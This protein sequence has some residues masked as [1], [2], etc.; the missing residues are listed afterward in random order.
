MKKLVKLFA[1][2][3]VLVTAVTS[4]TDEAT[5]RKRAAANAPKPVIKIV[6][7][8][9]PANLGKI[10]KVDVAA[11]EKALET[12]TLVDVRTPE[13]FAAGH[14]KGAVNINFKKRTF[15]DY[16]NAIAKDK[17]VAIYCRS[18]NRSGKAA[19]IMQ[20]LGFKEVID[21]GSGYKGWNKA[22]KE[23][24]KEDN[25][26]NKKLQETLAKGELKGAATVGKSHQI[27]VDEFEKLAKSGKVTVVDV[28]TAKEFA[29]GHIEGAI[30][31]DWKNRHFAKEAIKNITN[32]KPAAIYCRSGNRATRA[33]Y[34]MAALG[35]N[36]VYNLNKGMKSWNAANKPVKT[37]EVKG[38]KHHLDVAN[39]NNG[40]LGK[41]GKLVDI[42]TPKEY[43]ASHIPGAVM[44]DYKNDN[45]KE[46]FSK[47]DKKV[48]V[49]IYCRSGGRSGRA[50]KVLT[51]MGYDVYNLNKGFNEWK[52]EGMP[53]EGDSVGAAPAGGAEEGC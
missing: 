12:A 28:R 17:P 18:G 25:D 31:V 14:L 53:Q 46:E 26:A 35:F 45:F 40:I 39:F 5:I 13:E 8:I 32:D 37:L 47:L 41:V 21:L 1:L 48:P 49:L 22:G 50:T 52:A 10:N 16:I 51:K 43:N 38:D 9:A 2:A 30:N 34:A 11:F 44:I 20:S 33:M 4:C 7:A 36:E 15:P 6:E 42:R 19:F 24:V 23:V 29:A 3:I 27:G